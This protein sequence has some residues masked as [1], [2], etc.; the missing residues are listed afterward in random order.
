MLKSVYFGAMQWNE[1]RSHIRHF[2]DT[3]QERVKIAFEMGKEAHGEQ[4][5]KYGD[6]YFSHPIAVANMLAD[7]GADADTIVAALLHD[8]IE[9]TPL[10]LED[11]EKELDHTVS[12]LVDGVTKL[13]DA[14]FEKSPTLEGETETLRKIFTFMKQ[15]VRNMVIKLVD[16]LHNMQTSEYISKERQKS[17]TQET[18]DIYVKVAERLCMRDLRD[19][20]EELCLQ[21]LEPEPYEKMAQLRKKNKQRCQKVIDAIN[22]ALKEANNPLSQKV[23][24]QHEHKAWGKLR[25]QSA[26]GGAAVTGVS[27]LVIAF[28]CKDME[29]CYQ[30]FGILHQKW[31]REKLSF[32]DFINT[33]NINGYQGLH[34]TMIME[35]GTRIRCKIRTEEIHEYARKGITTKCFD[36]EAVGI[37]DY[38][39][40]TDRIAILSE[41]TTDQSAQFWESLQ[42]DI[43]GETIVIHGPNDRTIALP[44][45]ATALDGALYLFGEKALNV[46]SIKIDGKDVSFSTP[47]EHAATIDLILTHKAKVKREWLEW[48]QTGFATALIRN[49]LSHRSDRQ[50]IYLGK[51]LLQEA[52]TKQALGYLTEFKEEKLLTGFQ[53][54]GYSTFEDAIIAIADGHLQPSEA[55]STIFQSNNGS[56]TAIPKKHYCVVSFV[57]PTISLNELADR[58]AFVEKKYGI[59]LS[60]IQLHPISS[61]QVNATIRLPLSAEE[62]QTL[63]NELSAAGAGATNITINPHTSAFHLFSSLLIVL[64]LWGLD[65]VFA[66]LLILHDNLTAIDFTLLRFWSLTLTLLIIIAFGQRRKILQPLRLWNPL[67]WSSAVLL[68]LVALTTY[69]ALEGGTATH[70][71]IIMTASVLL[72]ATVFGS[73]SWRKGFTI[74]ALFGFVLLLLWNSPEW[75]MRSGIFML[76]SLVCFTAFL[77]VS[78]RYLRQEFIARRRL[79]YYTAMLTIGSICTIPLIAYVSPAIRDPLTISRVFLFSILFIGLPY[80][81]Y[82]K[83]SPKQQT[84]SMIPFAFIMLTVTFVGELILTRQFDVFTMLAY[85]A[86]VLTAYLLEKPQ[87]LWS[88]TG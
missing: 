81:L 66:R 6:L 47:L 87:K 40:W 45:G 68:T 83:W 70:Y 59:P 34:T 76:L 80:F 42:S 50:K 22:A 88:P 2:S 12:E 54:L 61:N 78:N 84:N 11:I 32:E 19:N 7:M 26:T 60:D 58:F 20:L 77:T 30:V 29:T 69:A 41:D 25:A 5:R 38:L 82:Y 63:A 67:L 39:P 15:D 46:E 17:F 74:W 23:N 8:A 71:E 10:T 65:P 44:K 79:E 9:D 56:E 48:V 16:R 73:L 21:I 33:P 43:L 1:F 86:M 14:E 55:I 75:N 27:A 72:A 52:M 85:T 24:V 35:D 37:L 51:Q 31:L 62:Q 28:I 36:S 18:M 4:K 3:D 49:V 57:L 13:D 53:A 64:L